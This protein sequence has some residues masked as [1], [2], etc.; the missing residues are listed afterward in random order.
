MRLSELL[1]CDDFR[2]SKIE[3]ISV[4]K[5]DK[6]EYAVLGQRGPSTLP[7]VGTTHLVELKEDDKDPE[8]DSHEEL[9]IRRRLLGTNQPFRPPDK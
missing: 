9:S 8:I 3:Q 4:W 5:T 2:S 1:R 6:C 7:G